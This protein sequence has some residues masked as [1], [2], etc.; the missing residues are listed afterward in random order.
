MIYVRFKQSKANML[1]YDN[2]CIV[3]GS[4]AHWRRTIEHF[5]FVDVNGKHQ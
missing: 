2:I 5:F 3:N 1:E 4:L